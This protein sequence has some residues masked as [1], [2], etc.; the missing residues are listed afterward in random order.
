[1]ARV[2]SLNIH[3]PYCI[4][5]LRVVLATVFW[6]LLAPEPSNPLNLCRYWIHARLMTARG[7]LG[8]V[9]CW[10]LSQ[11]AWSSWPATLLRSFPGACWEGVCQRICLLSMTL[12][13][14]DSPEWQ[15]RQCIL[16]INQ[17]L[18]CST[19]LSACYWNPS[20]RL[21]AA[22]VWRG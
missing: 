9:W 12:A 10:Y 22:E 4:P 5:G 19:R 21:P 11:M 15:K 17:E 13:G 20:T 2:L 7:L 1:M 18:P 3:S 14:H 16:F 8:P 6:V